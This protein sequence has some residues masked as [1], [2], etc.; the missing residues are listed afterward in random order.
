MT[1]TSTG[2]FHDPGSENPKVI[3][4]LQKIVH[5]LVQEFSVDG[6]RVDTLIYAR[7]SGPITKRPLA[8]GV[9]VKCCTEVSSSLCRSDP[10][11]VANF[12]SPDPI[13]TLAYQGGALSSVL[14]YPLY[15]PL[16]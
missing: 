9:R 3:L 14:N 8:S 12:V 10:D 1:P 11:S 13:Y 16:R 7:R 6:L 15:F 2:D 4:E 5:W